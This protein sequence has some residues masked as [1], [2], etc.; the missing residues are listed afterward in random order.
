MCFYRNISAIWPAFPWSAAWRDITSFPSLSQSPFIAIKVIK[1]STFL[2]FRILQSPLVQGLSLS[3]DLYGL[4]FCLCRVSIRPYLLFILLGA[5][6][7]ANSSHSSSL[8]NRSAWA[9]HVTYKSGSCCFQPQGE[10]TCTP[11]DPR[12]EQLVLGNIF[13]DMS[14]SLLHHLQQS[15]TLAVLR[16]PFLWVHTLCPCLSN[17]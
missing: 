1:V 17:S 9:K 15:C 10:G 6:W 7:F 16:E 8:V 2:H 12:P 11:Y 4:G 13:C 3:C 5:I 14:P